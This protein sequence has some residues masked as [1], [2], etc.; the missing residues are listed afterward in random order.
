[1][2]DKEAKIWFD[3]G[4]DFFKSQN[5]EEA[6]KCYAEATRLKPDNADCFN[7]WGIAIYKLATIKQEEALFKES[8]EKFAEA[9][10]L[11][12]NEA[13]CFN[14]WGNAISDLAKFKQDEALFREAFEKYTE[15]IRLKPDYAN[16]FYNWGNAVSDLATIKQDEALF[17]KS[18][19]KFSEAIRLNPNDADFFYGWGNAV[20]DLATI[21]QDEALFKESFEKYAEATRLN[22]NDADFFCGW[23]VAIYDFAQYKQDELLF[24]ESFEKYAEAT[25]LKQDSANVFYN[26]GLAIADLAKIKQDEILFRESFEKYA[27]ATRLNQVDADIFCGWGDAISDLA[28]I[29]Q[30]ESLFREAFEKYEKATRLN[31]DDSDTF[32]NWG[33]ALF[34]LYKIKQD[35][36]IASE[37]SK[38]FE[39]SKKDILEILAFLDKENREHIIQTEILYSLLDLDS[40]EGQFFKDTTKRITEKEELRKYKRAYIYS[41]FIISLLHINNENEK[42]VS[43]YLSKTVLQKMMFAVSKFRL[44]AINYSNDPKEGKTLLDYLFGI[45]SPAKEALNTDYSVF[46]SCFTFNYDSLNQFRLYGKEDGKEGTGL[47]LVFRD[48]FFDKE[49]KLALKQLKTEDNQLPKE[50]KYALFRCIYIDPETQRV[51]TVGYKENNLFYREKNQEDTKDKSEAYRTYI[52]D[53]TNEVIKKMSELKEMIKEL[54]PTIVGQ[55]L[56]NLR[57]LTKHVA[58]KEEQE[59]RIVKIYRLTNEKITTSDDFKQLY[60]DYLHIPNHIEKIYFGP[61]ATGMELFQDITKHKGL[62]IPFEKSKNPLA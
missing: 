31:P 55:L 4:N 38:C 39:E 50:E 7:S 45:Q 60:V 42:L 34:Q 48:S 29:K 1:M 52:N 36:S 27:E 53:L 37:A 57:Y 59:C 26:L 25:R 61:K 33:E 62:N 20:S 17:R 18:F 47:S 32:L 21:K 6:I 35:E 3:K 44:N 19:E 12:P 54:D 56:I 23:G 43:H 58:F 22:P 30:D 14:Y 16:A 15:A 49:A 24:R 41:V 5:F 2:E 8:F 9:T 46:A 11:N 40:D 13:D 28:T 10:R 51:E